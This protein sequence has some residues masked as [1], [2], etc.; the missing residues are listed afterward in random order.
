MKTDA[1]TT[2]LTSEALR[3]VPSE[4]PGHML[5]DIHRRMDD[6]ENTRL[7]VLDDSPTG[8]QTVHNIPVLT[9]WDVDELVEEMHHSFAFY[10]LTNSRI[11]PDKKARILAKEI[12]LALKA[13]SQKT[14]Y[15]LDV[16]SRSDSTLRGHFPAELDILA[17]ALDLK[18]APRLLIPFFEESGH[19]TLRG[20]HYVLQND[21]FVPVAQTE[22]AKD[23]TF[24]YKNSD[25]RKWV[26]EKTKGATKAKDVAC[27]DINLLRQGGAEK[28]SD[29]LL[30]LKPGS[31]A[32]VDSLSYRDQEMF[33]YALLGAQ[34]KGA[35]FLYRTSASFVRVRAGL[36]PKSVL[37]P[38]EYDHLENAYKGGLVVFGSYIRR[39]VEQ[40]ETL[41]KVEGVRGIEAD[42]HLLLDSKTRKATMDQLVER[43]EVC[44]KRGDDA[45]LY[46]SHDVSAASDRNEALRIATSVSSALCYVVHALSIPPR[47]LIAKG[48]V[49]S[50]DVATKGLGVVRA[51]V[52]GPAI[53]GVPVWRLGPESRFP[54][55]VYVIFPGHV[56]DP[57]SVVAV[58]KNARG[59]V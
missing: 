13:A 53:P 15:Q 31:V 57:D 45:V 40:L 9:T 39:S 20:I 12:G 34:A 11:L 3:G 32:V 17:E 23:S 8:T 14:G 55:L 27:I 2:L 24:G 51:L 41:L 56:G 26:E 29:A 18:D 10:I 49:T 25:L 16:V 33:V 47:F 38:I 50:S 21:Q 42:V 1:E 44:M 4:W 52:L 28:V 6:L 7:V 48:G 58:L 22:P 5:D 46:T 54:G 37:Q 43:V 19:Y 30:A 59:R 35:R 36:E